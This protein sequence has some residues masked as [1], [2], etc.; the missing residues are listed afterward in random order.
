MPA[1]VT[2]P[3][4]K[5]VAIEGR[6]ATDTVS[7]MGTAIVVRGGANP[8]IGP[9][10]VITGGY[11]GIDVGGTSSPSIVGATDAPTSITGPGAGGIRVRSEAAPPASIAVSSGGA[12]SPQVT[13]SNTSPGISVDTAIG[14]LGSTLD[15]LHLSYTNGWGPALSTTRA[16]VVKLTNSS[17]TGAVYEGIR[18]E[19]SGKFTAEGVSSISN[20]YA[21][22][23]V[24]GN[25]TTTLTNYTVRQSY[26]EGI[27]CYA[28][29]IKMRGVTSLANRNVGV[30]INGSCIA[31]LGTAADPGNNVFNKTGEKNGAAGLCYS[32]AAGTLQAGSST[33]SC[34]Y[35]GAG[36]VTTSVPT[37][38]PQGATFDCTGD[39]DIVEAT[40]GLVTAGAPSCCN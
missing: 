27:T 10:V 17:V 23:T 30:T 3:V 25:P 40:A 24:G 1:T 31:D 28:G 34:G 20:Y 19:G 16:A 12:A 8:Q 6:E 14:G 33:W 7:G 21:L 9:G 35:T 18:I 22:R 39:Y 4:V 15:G 37:R 38:K 26:Y 5:N 2:R 11:I 29:M 13:I 32:S 36:C